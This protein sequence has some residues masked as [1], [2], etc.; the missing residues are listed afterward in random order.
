MS[1][2]SL[3]IIT[4]VDEFVLV[5]STILS[6]SIFIIFDDTFVVD[7]CRCV[8]L[9]LSIRRQCVTMCDAR[10]RLLLLLRCCWYTNDAVFVSAEWT[11]NRKHTVSML[12]VSILCLVCLASCVQWRRTIYQMCI[13]NE[14]LQCV[15]LH[16]INFDWIPFC[17]KSKHTD[18]VESN[19]IDAHTVF[20]RWNV[21]FICLF[22]ASCINRTILL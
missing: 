10:L 15:I 1:R 8:S 22:H 7:Y 4:C 20:I 18:D 5:S 12:T 6:V 17:T 14:R 2:K 13:L 16:V 19:L 9:S 11:H 21:V 3:A